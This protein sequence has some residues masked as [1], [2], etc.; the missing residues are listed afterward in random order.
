ME[1]WKS[2]IPDLGSNMGK[3]HS[4]LAD[5]I[6]VPLLE[7]LVAEGRGPAV[8][9]AGS[10][11]G[12]CTLPRLWELGWCGA[13]VCVNAGC[14]KLGR[15]PWGCSLSLITGAHDFF[16]QS[17]NPQSLPGKMRKED[18]SAPILLYHSLQMG[19]TGSPDDF[20]R[21]GHHLLDSAVLEEILLLSAQGPQ[22]W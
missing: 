7:E 11:G 3:N 9:L 6:V 4:T 21:H 12:Q 10:R 14:T 1:G 13:A 22:S 19:H 20:D 5:N 8:I 15:L 17:A 18:H 16:K 2:G